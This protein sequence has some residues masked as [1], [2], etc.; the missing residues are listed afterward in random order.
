M[1]PNQIQELHHDA[2]ETI[3]SNS[4][5]ENLQLEDNK[6]VMEG[7]FSGC[8]KSEDRTE[9]NHTMWFKALFQ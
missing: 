5:G 2:V 4:K 7:Y 8:E 3:G 1:S 6:V 9:E